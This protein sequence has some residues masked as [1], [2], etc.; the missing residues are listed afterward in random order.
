MGPVF[1]D[2][3][4]GAV[5]V[6]VAGW[7]WGDAPQCPQMPRGKVI[8]VAYSAAGGGG[9]ARELVRGLSPS[10]KRETASTLARLNGEAVRMGTSGYE[11]GK[12]G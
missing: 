2:N 5:A 4:G 12:E 9:L 7:G 10:W 8:L 6:D 1:F 3:R 11:E